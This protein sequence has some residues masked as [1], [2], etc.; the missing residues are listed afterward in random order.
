MTACWLV[1]ERERALAE[2]LRKVR[3]CVPKQHVITAARKLLPSV[4]TNPLTFVIVINIIIFLFFSCP[5]STDTHKSAHINKHE[6]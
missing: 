6:T 5:A 1:S 2:L 4:L 3:T